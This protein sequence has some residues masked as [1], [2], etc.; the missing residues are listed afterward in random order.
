LVTSLGVTTVTL[1]WRIPIH[2]KTLLIVMFPR[3]QS[4]SETADPLLKGMEFRVTSAVGC[5][6]MAE[7]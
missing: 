2:Q 4:D 6:S 3:K 7:W 1:R 5:L